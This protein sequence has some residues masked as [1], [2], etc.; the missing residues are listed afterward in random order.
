M[1]AGVQGEPEGLRRSGSSGQTQGRPA[2][3]AGGPRPRPQP[4]RPEW[5]GAGPADRQAAGA[6]EGIPWS[7]TE[8]LLSGAPFTGPG[9]VGPPSLEAPTPPLEPRASTPHKGALGSSGC[10]PASRAHTGSCAQGRGREQR[11][12][13]C[14]VCFQ[15]PSGSRTGPGL[16]P[17]AEMGT[18]SLEAGTRIPKMTSARV[19]PELGYREPQRSALSAGCLQAWCPP[20]HSR[21]VPTVPQAGGHGLCPVGTCSGA[22]EARDHSHPGGVPTDP[23]ALQAD[24]C[25]CQAAPQRG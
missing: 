2:G 19:T 11:R 5:V 12:R 9:S 24:V 10:T 22:P 1:G 3:Q 6:R 20:G 7:P 25:P 8:G 16:S 14:P 13:G 21:Q 15:R 4:R 23:S 17:E 18:L